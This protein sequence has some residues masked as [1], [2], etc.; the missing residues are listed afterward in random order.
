MVQSPPQM[1]DPALSAPSTPSVSKQQSSNKP[2]SAISISLTVEE[3]RSLI[4]EAV[5]QAV[6]AAAQKA[7]PC[8]KESATATSPAQ[9]VT[10]QEN[11]EDQKSQEN[12][13]DQVI[14]DE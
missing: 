9:V 10:N 7:S 4:V 11:Q 14:N 13:S 3:L 2:S 8:G 6:G 12:I 5:Q 1:I